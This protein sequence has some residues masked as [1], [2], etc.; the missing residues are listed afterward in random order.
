VAPGVNRRRALLDA[1]AG[2][3]A[4]RRQ[5]VVVPWEMRRRVDSQSRLRYQLHTAV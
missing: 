2:R 1:R 4:G 3:A 5:P